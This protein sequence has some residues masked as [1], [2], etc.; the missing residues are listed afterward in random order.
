[1]EIE[2]LSKN[3]MDW[4]EITAFCLELRKSFLKLKYSDMDDKDLIKEI[5]AEIVDMKEKKWANEL[6]IR[7]YKNN[8]TGDI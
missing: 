7:L 6:N 2:R 5:F 3:L 4:P 1:M 8:F